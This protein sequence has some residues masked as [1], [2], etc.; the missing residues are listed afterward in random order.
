MKSE[1]YKI[2][3]TTNQRVGIAAS[4]VLHATVLLLCFFFVTWSPPN[5]PLPDYGVE[6]NFGVDPEGF[7]DL[8]TLAPA[9]DAENAQDAKPN[10]ITRVSEPEPQPEVAKSTPAPAV[11]E[12][13]DVASEDVQEIDS[14]VEV[15]I[16][17]PEAP[18]KPVEKPVVRAE[19]PKPIQAPSYT[20]EKQEEGGRGNKGTSSQ[21]AGNNNGD[22]PGKVGD[23]GDRRGTL[24]GKAL[25]GNPGKGGGSSLDMAGW[26]WDKRPDQT[27]AS[28]EEGRIVFRIKVDEEGNLISVSTLEKTVSPSVVS[29]Y[30]KQIEELTF[31]KTRDNVSTASESEGTI[32]VIVRS[33]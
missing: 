11:E 18:K 21:L 30:K 17:K 3:E 6:L 14:P 29:F 2:D 13:P 16:K 12:E 15:P 4:V 31:T 10:D 22:R 23:Q 26:I 5:P 33:N 27:D 19:N 1:S 9:N 7:G 8:Q 28:T 25:Y 24:D 20:P 32:T